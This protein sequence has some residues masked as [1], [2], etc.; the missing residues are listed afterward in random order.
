MTEYR[1]EELAFKLDLSQPL[2]GQVLDQMRLA[3]ARGEI[4]LGAKIPSIR[5]LALYLKVNP[6]TVMRAY[7]ELDR[8][9]LI[10][11][12]VG[13]G[14]YITSSAGKVDAIRKSLAQSAVLGFV[15]AMRKL[16][17]DKN[18]AEALLEEADWQ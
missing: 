1:A 4:E 16:G 11:S 18:T 3:L 17:L 10:E 7:Q 2:Y 12:R 9:G 13:Q 15:D 8:D 14:T 5:E 6:N